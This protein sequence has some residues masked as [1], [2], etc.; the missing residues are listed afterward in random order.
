MAKK[1]PE[2]FITINNLQGNA[3]WNKMRCQYVIMRTA[4]IIKLDNIKCWQRCVTIWMLTHYGNIKWYN[5]LRTIF[6]AFI[7]S[8]TYTYL[9]TQEFSIMFNENICPQN[10]LYKNM[11]SNFVCISQ[12]MKQ[13]KRPLMGKE[14]N[15]NIFV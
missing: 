7:W 3:D 6:S 1:A 4:K 2:K 10:V 15:Y 13:S 14:I 8:H 11:Y 9:I 12:K 5:H